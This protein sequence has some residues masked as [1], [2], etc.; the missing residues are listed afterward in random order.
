MSIEYLITCFFVVI[1]PGTGMIYTLACALGY[2][3][4]G[5]LWGAFGSTLSIVPH[6]LAAT[7]GLAAIMH[8][9]ALAFQ[10]IKIAG[11][12]YL[13]YMAW[14]MLRDRSQMGLDESSV[15]RAAVSSFKLMRNGVLASLLN[16][17]LSV[18]FLAFLPQFVDANAVQPVPEMLGLGAVFM[19]MTFVI[20]VCVGLGASAVRRKIFGRP[21]VIAWLKRL[22][23]G[24]FVALGVK[25]ALVQQ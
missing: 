11:V 22:F 20:F 5:A 25:L 2:G 21:R 8:A 24:T 15:T 7:L 9:S 23:A 10:L 13:L 19:G 6:I 16:P 17:K 18:F 1:T 14:S 3:A 12:C 4:R